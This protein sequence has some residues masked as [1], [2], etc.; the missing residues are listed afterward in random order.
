MIREPVRVWDSIHRIT[1]PS[2][3]VKIKRS[4]LLDRET[5]K[6]MVATLPNGRLAELDDSYHHAMLDNPTGLVAVL[7][8]F[9]ED[10]K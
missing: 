4:P 5:A 6:K 10:L 9:V 2:L 7:R 1:C 8:E 3:V